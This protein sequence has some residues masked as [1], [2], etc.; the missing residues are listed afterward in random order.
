MSE[1]NDRVH[2]GHEDADYWGRFVAAT[3]R[4][5]RFDEWNLTSRAQN[6]DLVLVYLKEPI[7]AFVGTCFVDSD[8]IPCPDMES[9]LKDK[10]WFHVRDA[11]TL[12]NGSVS[13]RTLKQR[14][15]AW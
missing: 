1:A 5:G 6:G 2:V 11:R 4:L 9:R 7:S 15:P 8:Q 12:P 14:F 3:E 13:I 10:P